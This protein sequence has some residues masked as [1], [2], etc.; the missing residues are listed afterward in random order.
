MVWE[1]EYLCI[2]ETR[3][4]TFFAPKGL[5]IS[6]YHGSSLCSVYVSAKIFDFHNML[7][8]KHRFLSRTDSDHEA[9]YTIGGSRKC[10]ARIINNSPEASGE[11][12]CRNPNKP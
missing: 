3:Y 7:E 5:E 10:I 12:I 6:M 8:G 9:K 11:S 1:G 2:W 4:V